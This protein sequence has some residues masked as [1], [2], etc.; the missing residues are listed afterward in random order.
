[1]SH[2]L[3]LRIVLLK[4]KLWRETIH[5]WEDLELLLPKSCR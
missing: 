2:V 4:T 3:E 5:R 1:M